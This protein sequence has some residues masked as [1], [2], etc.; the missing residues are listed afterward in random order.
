MTTKTAILS[1]INF[2]NKLQRIAY[3]IY[4]R[5]YEET[6]ILLIGIEQKGAF[7][8]ATLQ[9]LLSKITPIQISHYQVNMQR[10]VQGKMEMNWAE[11]SPELAGKCVIVI[12]DVLY[13]GRTLL[14]IFSHI[15]SYSPKSIQAFVLVDR[16]HRL[17][18][19][20]PD[21]VGMRLATTLQQH[22]S[23][24][25]QEDGKAEIFLM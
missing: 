16:G 14:S 3:Q 13:S 6:E 1:D 25:I 12:D 19:I 15:L 21:Y 17:M 11:E 20:S 9:A 22:V 18:P 4:E 5:N 24:E 23:F 8:A 7:I 2:R 10:N